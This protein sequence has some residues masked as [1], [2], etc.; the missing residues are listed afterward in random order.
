MINKFTA[1]NFYSFEDEVKLSFLVDKKA[2]NSNSFINTQSG[3]RISL[4]EAII[5]PNASGK[6]TA[7]KAIAFVQW[8]IVDSYRR[9][10]YHLPFQPY[11]INKKSNKPTEISVDF[12]IDSELFT[13][14]C[15]LTRQRLIS[16]S[17]EVKSKSIERI[18]SKKLFSRK[19]NARSKRYDIDDIGFGL[20][21]DYID[22]EELGNSS[23]ISA[24]SRF[25]HTYSKKISDY[26]K[27]VESNIDIEDTWVPHTYR[28]YQA[29][30]YF[31]Q[32][33]KSRERVEKTLRLYDIGIESLNKDGNVT[34]KLNDR[35]VNLDFDDE[36]SGTKQLFAVLKMIDSV[37]DKGSIAIIDE[38]EAYLHP[39]MFSELVGRFLDPNT[40][41]KHAQLLMSTHSYEILNSLNRQQIILAEKNTLGS[42]YLTRLD[43]V[44][45]ARADDNFHN[46]YLSGK[47]GAIPNIK[48]NL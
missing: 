23:L 14:S 1:K 21:K 9:N 19:W 39:N 3:A 13:Y 22:T 46:K 12:E 7:L 37:L 35:S 15:K 31:E 29:L 4:V 38:F 28:A 27:S 45:A 8:L 20:P 47:Y 33:K 42:S 40:N 34:H 30:K 11:A 41:P 26:W 44:D 18:T 10:R 36:S 6:T 25:G 2:P 43:E 16:E 5:G 48:R 32:H 24:A 17:L